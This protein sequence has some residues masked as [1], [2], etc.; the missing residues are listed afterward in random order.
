VRARRMSCTD[1]CWRVEAGAPDD[2]S[3]LPATAH[4]CTSTNSGTL[5]SRILGGKFDR[6]KRWLC[7]KLKPSANS[8]NLAQQLEINQMTGT[9]I[10]LVGS[11]P[12]LC[13]STHT[14]VGS[15][16]AHRW[17]LG[18]SDVCYACMTGGDMWRQSAFLQPMAP[19]GTEAWRQVAVDDNKEQPWKANSVLTDALHRWK[20]GRSLRM[21]KKRAE[22]LRLAKLH[23]GES[24]SQRCVWH[25]VLTGENGSILCFT[26]SARASTGFGANVLCY[27]MKARENNTVVSKRVAIWHCYSSWHPRQRPR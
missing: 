2:I 17:A 20:T 1:S 3:T 6:P 8:C 22:T 9:C 7:S 4:A 13:D 25:S 24:V 15:P 11:I 14:V 18:P 12:S 5:G 26:V 23:C 16:V 10:T 27:V 19:C 21:K